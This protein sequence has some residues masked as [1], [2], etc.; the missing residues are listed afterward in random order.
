MKFTASITRRE[1]KRWLRSG[2]IV[3]QTRWIVNYRE[4][5]TGRRRQLFFERQK[6]AI[7]KRDA[8]MSTVASGTYSESKSELTVAQAVEHWLE[9]RRTEVKPVTWNGYRRAVHYIIG[10]LMIGTARERK[11]YTEAEKKPAS[12]E[13]VEMLGP[14][15]IANLTTGDVRRWHKTVSAQ[16]S[17]HSANLAKTFL[18]SALAL[19]AE[20][21]HLRVPPMPLNLGRNRNKQKK[22]ILTPD[23]VGRIL[24]AAKGDRRQ[25]IYYAFPFL[26]GVRPSEQLALLWDDVNFDTGVIKICRMQ[27][28]N[29]TLCEVT[30]TV[31]GLREIPMPPLLRSMLLEWR[32][33]CPRLNGSLHRVF[34][35]PGHLLPWSGPRKVGGGALH[36]ANFRNRFWRPIFTKLGLPYV[37]PHSARHAFI[38]TLQAKGIEVGL[39]AKLAGHANAAITL[40]HYTQAVRGGEAA[41]QALEDAYERG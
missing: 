40:S 24:K 1:R 36:Y 2:A 20:D 10:P 23:Q 7:A 41:M 14:S 25:G 13:F 19:A 18:R 4:P 9:H 38:S 11:A 35:A 21:F 28:R 27:E 15:S 16:V 30:K 8:L 12:A 34:P 31:A 3:M 29:G 32:L 5:R 22:A 33:V 37:T 26:T 17:T 39:V 6:D